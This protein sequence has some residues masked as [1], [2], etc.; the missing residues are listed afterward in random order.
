[1]SKHTHMHEKTNVY[2]KT[3][4]STHTQ[5]TNKQQHTG[6]L[7]TYCTCK[8]CCCA[9]L[10]WTCLWYSCSFCLLKTCIRPQRPIYTYSNMF[11]RRMGWSHNTATNMSYTQYQ[12]IKWRC[13]HCS[14][15]YEEIKYSFYQDKLQKHIRCLYILSRVPLYE[16]PRRERLKTNKRPYP[17]ER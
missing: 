10:C 11:S 6:C 7:I 4:I 16:S 8:I 2:P 13:L 1:M 17:R 5:I 12:S 3:W 15:A 9:C 14:V